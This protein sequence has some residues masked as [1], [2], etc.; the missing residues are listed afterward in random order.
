MKQLCATLFYTCVEVDASRCNIC[1]AA[2]YSTILAR[3]S[4]ILTVAII[5]SYKPGSCQHNNFIS[6]H[7][8]IFVLNG[9]TPP[10]VLTQFAFFAP[11]NAVVSYL[12]S[13]SKALW[14]D[15]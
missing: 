9:F 1:D 15:S 7:A 3:I 6:A 10:E 2:Y 14:V 5:L 12:N 4:V 11:Q 8:L 13:Q